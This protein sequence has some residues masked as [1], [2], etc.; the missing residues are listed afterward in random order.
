VIFRDFAAV[1]DGEEESA[2]CTL[3]VEV[4]DWVGVPV[5]WPVAPRFSPAGKEP[6]VKVHV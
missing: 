4:P 1:C 5:I 2:N 6:E 3:N